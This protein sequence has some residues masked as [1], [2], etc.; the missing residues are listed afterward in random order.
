MA[1]KVVRYFVATRC[2]TL[3][4]TANTPQHTA[5]HALTRVTWQVAGNSLKD[6]SDGMKDD[7]EV[8]KAAVHANANA[9]QFASSDLKSSEDV[10]LT[11]LTSGLNAD[12][13]MRV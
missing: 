6:A 4:F 5:A 3:Q 2:H 8:V 11:A 13:V 12:Q 10:A 9:L 7:K 1:V